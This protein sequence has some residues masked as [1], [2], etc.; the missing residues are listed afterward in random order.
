MVTRIAANSLLWPASA[1]G[2]LLP[3]VLTSAVKVN[4]C[5]R[6]VRMTIEI[7]SQ[8]LRSLQ[9]AAGASELECSRELTE[10]SEPAAFE[11]SQVVAVLG[12]IHIVC[13]TFDLS[14][15]CRRVRLL[16]LD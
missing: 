12:N 15:G 8:S 14:G 2:H 16:Y 9:R 5:C 10:L 1:A 6:L 4:K 11:L 7:E 13:C 3:F